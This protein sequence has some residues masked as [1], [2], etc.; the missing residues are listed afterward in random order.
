M[1]NM[2]KSR[3]IRHL[4]LNSM[5]SNSPAMTARFAERL[6]TYMPGFELFIFSLIH[7]GPMRC[8]AGEDLTEVRGWALER[9]NAA[10]SFHHTRRHAQKG[11]NDDQIGE[12]LDFAMKQ[13]IRARRHV[14][15]RAACGSHGGMRPEA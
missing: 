11:V 2:A 13:R 14:S 8:V 6:A 1:E 4:M 7:C 9:L 15:T 5:A 3:P 10:Q 12:I